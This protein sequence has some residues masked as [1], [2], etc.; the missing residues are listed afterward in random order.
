MSMPAIPS[1]APAGVP[2][3]LRPRGMFLTPWGYPSQADRFSWALKSPGAGEGW[4]VATDAEAARSSAEARKGKAILHLGRLR[5]RVGLFAWAAG[6]V[7]AAAPVPVWSAVAQ[8]YPGS[9]IG[10]FAAANLWVPFVLMAAMTLGLVLMAGG[11]DVPDPVVPGVGHV[12]PW[13]TAFLLTDAGVS[14]LRRDDGPSKRHDMLASSVTRVA[15][16]AE[17][18]GHVTVTLSTPD[19]D[20]VMPWLPDAAEVTGTVAAWGCKAH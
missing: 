6:I 17:D 13:T 15:T 3:D 20:L 11:D 9:A 8:A 4:V 1:P 5:L 12:S 16:R 19:G 18:A 14:V 7:L 10:G 2:S